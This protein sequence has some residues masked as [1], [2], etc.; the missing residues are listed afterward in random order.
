MDDTV[1]FEVDGYD[2][3]QSMHVA[4]QQII[5]D[6][7]LTGLPV[8]GIYGAV[9][10]LMII[11]ESETGLAVKYCQFGFVEQGVDWHISGKTVLPCILNPPGFDTKLFANI[12]K[13]C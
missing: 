11:A 10:K 12:D 6:E 4:S 5:S 1:I 9:S 7:D 13:D 3:I 8:H 2:G